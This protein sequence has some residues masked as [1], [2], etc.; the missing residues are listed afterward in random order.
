M[1]TVDIDVKT[2]IT[3]YQRSFSCFPQAQPKPQ[4]DWMLIT[5][6]AHCLGE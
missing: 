5:Y 1:Y 4:N 2:D 3:N 6:T